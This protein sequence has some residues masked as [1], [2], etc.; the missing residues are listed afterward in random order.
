MHRGRIK[1]QIRYSSMCRRFISIASLLLLLHGSSSTGQ[2]YPVHCQLSVPS[3]TPYSLEGFCNSDGSQM[4]LRIIINDQT[5]T[6][7]PVKMRIQ[8]RS[9]GIEIRTG[10]WFNPQPLFLTAGEPLYLDGTSLAPWFDPQNLEFSG[11]SREQYLRNRQLPEGMYQLSVVLFDYYRD[12]QVSSSPPALLFISLC[13][14]PLLA[15]PAQAA[16]II[17]ETNQLLPFSWTSR[18]TSFVYPGFVPGYELE[19]W[20]IW[21]DS[22]SPEDLVVS[23]PPDYTVSSAA[24]ML[25]VNL[26]ELNL[27]LGRRYVWRVRISDPAGRAA[28]R[29]GGCSQLRWFRYGRSCPGVDPTMISVSNSS[30]TLSWQRAENHESFELRYRA[31]QQKNAPWYF[32]NTEEDNQRI[33]PLRSDAEYE[34]QL[35]AYCASEPTDWSQTLTLR[36]RPGQ[37]TVCGGTLNDLQVKNTTPLPALLRG[38]LIQAADFMVEVLEVTGSNGDFSG[39]GSLL[40]PWLNAVKLEVVF[41]HIGVNNEYR[42]FR[43][44]I[45]SVYRLSNSLLM[46]VGDFADLFRNEPEQLEN[47]YTDLAD[48]IVHTDSSIREILLAGDGSIILVTTGGEQIRVEENTGRMVAVETPS[49]DQFLIDRENHTV[50]SG[51]S[52]P[53]SS[54]VREGAAGEP[55]RY[56]VS[57][58][59]GRDS[60]GGYDLPADNGPPEN[61]NEAVLGGETK[62]LAWISLE[63]GGSTNVQANINGQ[64]PDSVK[65]LR[66]SGNLVMAAPGEVPG[67]KELL[68]TGLGAG[69]EEALQAFYTERNQGKTDSLQEE[70][71]L[72]AGQVQLVSYERISCRLK[73]VPVNG[74]VCPDPMQVQDYLNRVY[75]PAMVDFFVSKEDS[76]SVSLKSQTGKV[77]DNTDPDDRMNYTGEMKTVISAY[78]ENFSGSDEDCFF[79]FFDGS[80]DP[81]AEGY[82]PFKKRYGFIYKNNQS[83]DRWLRTLAHELGHGAFRLRHTYSEE[84][85]HRQTEGSTDNLMDKGGSS[86]GSGSRSV[87]LPVRSAAEAGGSDVQ[88]TSGTSDPSF[89]HLYKY[90]WDQVQDPEARVNWWEEEEEGEISNSSVLRWLISFVNVARQQNLAATPKNIIPNARSEWRGKILYITDV[91]F[92]GIEYSRIAVYIPESNNSINPSAEIKEKLQNDIEGFKQIIDIGGFQIVCFDQKPWDCGFF[93]FTEFSIEAW[94][95]FV[96]DACV[97]HSAELNS[98]LINYITGG[99]IDFK[100]YVVYKADANFRDI[101]DPEKIINPGKYIEMGREVEIVFHLTKGERPRALI[102]Y[103]GET[104]R[105]CT[106]TTNLM[107]IVTVEDT[108]TYQLKNDLKPISFPYSNGVKDDV[109]SLIGLQV[110]LRCGEYSHIQNKLDD[111]LTDLGWVLS[112]DLKRMYINNY[113]KQV[114]EKIFGSIKIGKETEIVIEQSNYQKDGSFISQSSASGCD[115]FCTS[116]KYT[117]TNPQ[118][119]NYLFSKVYYMPTTEKPILITDA[120]VIE[121]EVLATNNKG[122]VPT[123]VDMYEII[124]F[125]R[126]RMEEAITEINSRLEIGKPT[127]VGVTYGAKKGPYNQPGYTTDHYIVIVAKGRDAGG[128]YFRYLDP[129]TSIGDEVERKLYIME[130]LIIQGECN[131]RNNDL[132]FLVELRLEDKILPNCNKNPEIDPLIL[133]MKEEYGNN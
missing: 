114:D 115:C 103:K 116:K 9:N 107:E 45:N 72:L 102:R 84:N 54:P 132:Y 125:E 40:V 120:D 63:A 32:S 97:K 15:L 59:P 35:R 38:D 33:S 16:E 76:F 60:K 7:Y 6:D 100:R 133:K 46:Q 106:A 67:R 79:F 49:G 44:C 69:E 65:F 77:L 128:I 89:T 43:G 93:A 87:S 88:S 96:D 48:Q 23:Q 121:K 68:I 56:M 1:Y 22:R 41:E 70:E 20:E 42:L 25:N 19:L 36:T 110:S 98:S 91:K 92:G 14:P 29:N 4:G 129:G 47:P 66:S 119:K 11:I 27:V 34:F 62:Q 51:S 80:V 24:T 122:G 78:R 104:E 50:Y 112:T 37:E 82:M 126:S 118:F 5:L 52:K 13:D 95:K 17:P 64:P 99:G 61:Y 90:Q 108:T 105:Y 26:Q 28:F 113:Y 18:H 127:I 73:L 101:N 21:P 30:A 81:S 74:S 130:D 55:I 111:T 2:V 83:S 75:A 117:G 10:S 31:V 12:I 39:R 123:L 57:F 94:N 86:S 85:E 131:Y 8:I 124:R 109:S 58:S 71:N 53:P 3:P